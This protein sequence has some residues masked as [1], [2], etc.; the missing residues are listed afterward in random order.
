MKISFHSHTNE[1][2]FSYEK[3]STKTRFEKEATGNSEM[4]YYNPLRSITII[5]ESLHSI[6][7]AHTNGVEQ[8]I[9]PIF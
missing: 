1:N 5:T 2:S 9:W 6:F 8:K 7:Y 4:A 3:M